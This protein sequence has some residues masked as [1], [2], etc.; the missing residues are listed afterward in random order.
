MILVDFSSVVHR[1]IHSSIN[2]MKPSKVDGKYVTSEYIG[3][4]KY[5]IIKELF[6]IS[7]EYSN[8]YGD[9]VVCLDDQSPEGYWRKDVLVSYKAGRS[10]GRAESN[11]IFSEIWGEVDSITEML[12]NYSP[13]KVVKTHRAEADDVILILADE[14]NK[15]ER[16]L[17]HSPDKDMIQSQIGTDNV[18]QISPLTKQWLKAETKSDDMDGWILEHIC[19]GDACD[20][21]PKVTDWTEFSEAF[22][23]HLKA[24]GVE[25]LTP[26]DFKKTPREVKINV[27]QSFSVYKKNRKGEDT[28][29][30]VYKD[31]SFGPS[32]LRKA[33]KTHGSLDGWLDTHPLYREHYERNRILVLTEGIPDYIRENTL[34]NFFEASNEFVPLEFERFL[35]DNSLA[36][37]LTEMPPQLV[38]KR[39]ISAADFDW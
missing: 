6:D 17:I 16:I 4:L 18:D 28:I 13:W 29:L 39:E 33:I 8:K 36:M 35:K 23:D 9:I 24:S 32:T 38:L 22:I 11:V 20:E 10:K 27:L 30:D 7:K 31:I 21:V 14:F 37:L 12:R 1:K 19:L 26:F 25:E 2:E 3:I 15:D 5:N 34:S